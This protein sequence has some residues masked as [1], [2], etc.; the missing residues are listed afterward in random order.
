[1]HVPALHELSVNHFGYSLCTMKEFVSFPCFNVIVRERDAHTIDS[2]VWGTPQSLLSMVVL[3][4]I[5]RDQYE[6]S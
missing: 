5:G 2:L 6:K 3:N 4:S 1:M